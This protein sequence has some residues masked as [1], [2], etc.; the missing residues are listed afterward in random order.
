MNTKETP[1]VSTLNGQAVDFLKVGNHSHAIGKLQ[2]ALAAVRSNLDSGESTTE[3]RRSSGGSGVGRICVPVGVR[4]YFA[5]YSSTV[6]DEEDGRTD[7]AGSVFRCFDRAFVLPDNAGENRTSC[8]VLYNLG[9]SHTLAWL[10]TH[11]ASDLNMAIKL[12]KMAL[13]VAEN[14]MVEETM[15]DYVLLQLLALFNNLGYLQHYHAQSL[16]AARQAELT[17]HCVGAIRALIG[18]RY[19]AAGKQ[20]QEQA[21]ARVCSEEDFLFFRWSVLF[22]FQQKEK[23]VAPAA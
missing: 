19:P 13:S 23:D 3:S 20:Q 15:D 7:R 14:C 17:L 11:Q 8:V 4:A 10:E 2:E 12:Y 5:V 9:L 18:T 1:R 16:S 6:D 21:V 22:L